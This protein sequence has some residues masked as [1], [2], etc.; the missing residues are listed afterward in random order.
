MGPGRLATLAKNLPTLEAASAPAVGPASG[1][2]TNEALGRLKQWL[3]G[4]V[5]ATF[6]NP[7]TV[8]NNESTRR[9]VETRLAEAMMAQLEK[10]AR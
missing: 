2:L 7:A 5:S 8:M 1:A 3:M 6:E 4:R 9:E 10:V